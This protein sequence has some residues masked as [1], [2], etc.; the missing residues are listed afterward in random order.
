MGSEGFL[1]LGLNEEDEKLLKQLLECDCGMKTILAFVSSRLFRPLTSWE[2]KILRNQVFPGSKKLSDVLDEI[3]KDSIVFVEQCDGEITQVSLSHYEQIELYK[4][5]PEVLS[6]SV[7]Y[8]ACLVG[9]T[10]FQV[11][12]TDGLLCTRPIMFSLHSTEQT[13]DLC[14]LLKHFREIFKDVSSTLTVAVDC[15]VSKPELVQ[16]FFPTSRIVLSSS[17]VRKV[18]KRKFKS[19]VAN[20]IFAGLTSTLCPNK[21]KS[22]LQNMKKLDSEVYDYVIQHWIPIKEM[23]V[24]A[25]LQN[26]VTLGTKVNGVV[27]CVHPRIREALKENNSLKDCLMALHKEVKKYCNLLENETSLRLLKHK[28]FNV[29][30]ELHEFLNQLTDYAS[31]K[32]YN[33]IVRESDI[34]IEQVEDDCVFCSDDGNSYRVDRNNGVCSCSL[35]SVELLP[36]RHLMKVHFS[37]GLHTGTPCRYPRW[38]RSHNLQPL[39]TAPTRDKRID[40]NSAMAMVIRKLKMLQDQC[41]PTVVFETVNRINAIIEKSTTE[42]LCISPTL[43]DS[44]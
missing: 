32:T 25:F 5:F 42:N 33:D 22:D 26:V 9:F 39:S 1:G 17:Y 12:V 15:P 4:R 30:E 3:R 11:A 28:R 37:M 43:S 2:I 10:I 36:C 6:F 41:S 23:W 34:T 20:K 40:V 29:D 18:F 7:T 8:N 14:V 24:P 31:D 38:L 16:E 27:K 35:N 44:F 19:P 13:E 21:F